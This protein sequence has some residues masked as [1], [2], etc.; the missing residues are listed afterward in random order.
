M[1]CDVGYVADNYYLTQAKRMLRDVGICRRCVKN[2]SPTQN[3]VPLFNGI[4]NG[5][6]FLGYVFKSSEF[7]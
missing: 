2:T 1:C 3:N 7:F 5:T 4:S 6:S